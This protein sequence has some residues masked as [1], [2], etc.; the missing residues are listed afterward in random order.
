MGL[1]YMLAPADYRRMPWKNGG[2]HTW[3]IAA[4]PP[5]AD[6]A[7]FAWRVSVAAVERDGPFSAFAGVSRTLV[8][9]AGR[10]IRLCG[11][12]SQIELT[13]PFE[14]V[15]FAGDAPIECAL[16]DGPTRDFNLMVRHSQASAQLHVVRERGEAL[17]PASVHV[18]YAARAAC[19]CLVA[20]LPP[21]ELAPEHTLVADGA[22]AP[23]GMRV[24]PLSASSVA[25]VARIERNAQ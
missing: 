10:G 22:F 15:T 3:E 9:L 2:G 14:P 11:P 18:C 21:F 6:L 1:P 4:D 17:P 23:G 7:S 16:I 25:L 8:L 13:A 24:N 12:A 5:G 20:G 19:E